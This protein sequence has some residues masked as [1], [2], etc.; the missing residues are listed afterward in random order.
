MPFFRLIL[1]L[2]LRHKVYVYSQ[3]EPEEGGW[4]KGKGW[5]DSL[6]ELKLL[7]VI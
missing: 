1:L 7:G 3:Q 2:L 5:K 6:V 4:N